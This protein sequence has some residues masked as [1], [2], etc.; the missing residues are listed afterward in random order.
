MSGQIG[1]L[2]RA[3]FAF[4]AAQ[5]RQAASHYIE[6]RTDHAKSLATGYAV[7]A[8]LFAVAG[9]F[10]LGACA[11]GMVALYFWLEPQYGPFASLGIC[12]GLLLVLMVICIVAAMIRMR[13]KPP[14]FPSLGERLGSAVKGN[15]F[16]PAIKATKSKAANA[17]STV[18]DTAGA[19]TSRIS[20]QART[21]SDER[22][23]PRALRR[24]RRTA[25]DVLQGPTWRGRNPGMRRTGLALGAGLLGW[26][27]VRRRRNAYAQALPKR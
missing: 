8:G 17:V 13:A 2:L 6:D 12:A 25:L 3:G 27:L 15:P 4:K 26:A 11:V 14:E 7:A 1:A 23:G 21:V 10:L 20:E 16:A 5:L 19:A 22:A 24:A 9:V 18:A